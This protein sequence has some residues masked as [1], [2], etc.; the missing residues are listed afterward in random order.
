M[1]KYLAIDALFEGFRLL[2]GSTSVVYF[3]SKGFPLSGIAGLKMVQSVAGFLLEVPTGLLADALDR[4]LVLGLSAGSGALAFVGYRY[5]DSFAHF[6][7]AE[8]ALALCLAIWSGAYEAFA[9]DGMGKETDTETTNRFFHLSSAVNSA[10][11]AAGGWL[12]GIL[13]TGRAALPFECSA[14]GLGLIGVAFL[15]AAKPGTSRSKP[16]KEI[17]G[18][19][20]AALGEKF[21]GCVRLFLESPEARH[22]LLVFAAVQFAMQPLIYYWQPWF[23][24]GAAAPSLGVVYLAFQ[25]TLFVVGLAGARLSRKPWGRGPAYQGVAWCLLGTGIMAMGPLGATY[26]GLVAFCVAEAGMALGMASLKSELAEACPPNLR[27]SAFSSLAL[28]GRIGSMLSLG[29]AAS[30]LSGQSGR[31]GT[32]LA[33]SGIAAAGAA[34][35]MTAV[36]IVAAAPAAGKTVIKEA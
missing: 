26:G 31:L 4:R 32:V 3:M 8:V 16:L 34:L 28:C 1:R 9:L 5:G 12:G 23:D 22:F 30:L 15:A 2:T 29:M 10:A 20:V 25:A 11:G 24:G 17:L 7:L 36:A 27:A 19:T 14:A 6:A 35:L 21:R 33:I 18:A 13:A